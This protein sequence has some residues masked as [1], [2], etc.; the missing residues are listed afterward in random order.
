MVTQEILGFFKDLTNDGELK[1]HGVCFPASA[2]CAP[3]QGSFC[4]LAQRGSGLPGLRLHL[5]GGCV[6]AACVSVADQDSVRLLAVEGCA[7][8]GKLLDK[9]DCIT[10]I[11]PSLS[12]S[13]RY[14]SRPSLVQ[15]VAL[16]NRDKRRQ[17]QGL[18]QLRLPQCSHRF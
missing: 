13:H 12:T 9:Q 2:R 11:L 18:G 17:A 10:S 8:I 15:S 16:T 5:F 1:S 3:D 14:S 4:L 6:C 7:A